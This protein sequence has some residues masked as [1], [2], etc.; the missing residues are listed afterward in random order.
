M[1][2]HGRCLTEARGPAAAA[3]G[4]ETGTAAPELLAGR[5]LG[6]G[7]V[8]WMAWIHLHLWS[9]GYKHIPSIG[10]LFLLNFIAGVLLA[11]SLLFAPRRY[12]ALVAG[13]GTL[14]I[15]GTLGSLI[16]SINIGL[17]GF[18]DSYQAPFAHLSIGVE[19]AAIIVLAATAWRAARYLR[20]AV[21]SP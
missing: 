2:P 11:L 7:L 14:M 1:A 16:I 9:E 21:P 17:F 5:I 3:S 8:G 15:L 10:N 6:A 20:P 18:Q 4:A 12:L 19:A 13:A